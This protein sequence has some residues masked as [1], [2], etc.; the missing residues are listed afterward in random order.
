MQ[1]GPS[2]EYEERVGLRGKG[3]TSASRQGIPTTETSVL[4]GPK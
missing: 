3:Q 2:E 4:S 1:L